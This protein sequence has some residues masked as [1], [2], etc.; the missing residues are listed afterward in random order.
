MVQVKAG[1][2][3]EKRDDSGPIESSEFNEFKG[4]MGSKNCIFQLKFCRF[5]EFNR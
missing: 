2:A 4:T 5:N 3:I 1:L